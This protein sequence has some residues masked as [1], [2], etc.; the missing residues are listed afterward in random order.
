MRPPGHGHGHGY[1]YGY[2]YGYAKKI[3]REPC[4]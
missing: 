1:G 4:L 3:A 2:G